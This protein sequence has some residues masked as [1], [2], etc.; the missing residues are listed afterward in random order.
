MP[1]PS[2]DYWI[3]KETNRLEPAVKSTIERWA[4]D[5][6][7]RVKAENQQLKNAIGDILEAWTV[8]NDVVVEAARLVEEEE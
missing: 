5:E 7:T 4:A 6:L 2:I 1:K 8:F 3:D